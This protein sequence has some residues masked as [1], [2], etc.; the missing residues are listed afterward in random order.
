[1]APPA[2]PAA[3]AGGVHLLGAGAIGLLVGAAFAEAGVPCTLLL[4]SAERLAALRAGGGAVT[5]E[6]PGGAGATTVTLEGELAG[7]AGAPHIGRLVVATKANQAVDA[8]AAVR[9]R[10]SRGSV[11]L[12][13]QNGVLG[14]F[15]AA[16]ALWPRPHDRPAFLLGSTTHGAF[17]KPGAPFTVVHA[18]AGVGACVYGPPST[19]ALQAAAAAAAA[20]AAGQHAQRRS[21][22]QQEPPADQQDQAVGEML[23]LLGRGLRSLHPQALDAGPLERELL[24]KLIVNCCANPLTALLHCR[25]R[26]LVG[27]AHVAALWRAVVGEAKAVLGERLPGS[28]EELFAKVD[29]VMTITGSNVNSMLQDTLARGGTEVNELNG[30]LAAEGAA[31]G[32]PTPVND[33]LVT[34]VR[35]R[36]AACAARAAAA[37]NFSEGPRV[38]AT[39][40]GS[41]RNRS[42][43]KRAESE[44]RTI[45]RGLCGFNAKQLAA[46]SHLL[47]EEHLKQIRIA[48]DIPPTNQGRRRQEGLV[49]KLMRADAET[50]DLAKLGEAV[51]VAERN[52]LPFTDAAVE[53]QLS[54]WIEGLLEDRQEVVDELHQLLQESAQDWQQLRTWVRQ[55]QQHRQ[56]QEQQQ[57]AQQAAAADGSSGSSAA[58]DAVELLGPDVVAAAVDPE[59]VALMQ[60]LAQQRQQRPA[61]RGGKRPKSESAAAASAARRSIRKLLKPMAVA[62][63]AGAP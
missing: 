2:V 33:L 58:D 61:S 36:E 26:G 41:R 18:S 20:A 27:N 21:D 14:V 57:Q 37:F 9:H 49:V 35:A 16:A 38:K 45:V 13:L 24:H 55:V 15:S 43:E 22:A 23:A 25:N 6:R 46:V 56:Q 40:P 10:L 32:V 1:M 52:N 50:L 5:V 63:S 44:L 62:R 48:M 31:R 3:A 54:W 28:E 47:P 51:A 34:L 8:L 12:L 30:W 53:Q 29:H 17:R 60:E 11:V 4:R 39:P 7:G 59:V 42:V 19:A